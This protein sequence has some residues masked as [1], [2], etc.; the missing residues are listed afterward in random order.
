[1]LRLDPR[2]RRAAPLA[3]RESLDRAIHLARETP[4]PQRAG[5][6]A[7]DEAAERREER[8]VLA[9]GEPTEQH[10]AVR[11]V[12]RRTAGR[13]PATARER[14]EAREGAQERRLAGAVRTP[15]QRET[16]SEL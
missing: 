14:R 4:S 16:R 7:P 6:V 2:E 13:A 1:L 15:Q 8:E 10:R 9:R 12:Q 3:G 5:D 11:D